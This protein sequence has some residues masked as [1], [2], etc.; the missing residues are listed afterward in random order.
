MLTTLH[1]CTALRFEATRMSA[2][3][4]SAAVSAAAMKAAA[5]AR[6]PFRSG[7]LDRAVA[8]LQKLSDSPIDA[9]ALREFYASSAHHNH[10]EWARTEQNAAALRNV[11]GGPG[12][13]AFDTIFARVLGDGNY[14]AA[15]AAAEARGESS[16]P[17]VVLVTGLNGIRKTTSVH[18]PWF[19]E[20]LAAA[21]GDQFG[22]PAAEL[23]DGAN[24][25]FRQLD[26]MVATL[27]LT[28][29]EALYTLQDVAAYAE[30]KDAIFA[31]YRTAA[32]VLGVLLLR[33]AEERRMNVMVETSGRDIGMFEYVEH[34]FP[35]D[36]YRK[37]VLNFR[38]NTLSFAER[39]VD[40]RMLREMADGSAALGGAP[41]ALVRAN[42]G[43]PYGSAALAGV[44]ADSRRVW[45]SVVGGGAGGVG[46]SWL[47]ASFEIDAAA[48][49]P[50][51]C[52]PAAAGS[53]RFEFVP[54]PGATP[55]RSA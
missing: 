50:W 20:A 43:G 34:L 29:F 32:E 46:A 17:W 11:V 22:G 37:L 41:A 27:A 6:E 39:S 5:V 53:R 9:Q 33:A 42:A 15:A 13:A 10:K 40:A 25:F 23:P 44:Q 48:D 49:A 38:I 8:S 12:T 45:E 30:R 4:E 18:Q 36:S 55:C 28:E 26:Y 24:S 51:T 3:A 14:D 19:K 47:K 2:P 7:E 54:P 16:K 21:L 1:A 35:S 52:R 31:R